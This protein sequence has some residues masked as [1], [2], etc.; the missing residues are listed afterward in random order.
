MNSDSVYRRISIRIVRLSHHF[1]GALFVGS[2]S[3]ALPFLA[4]VHEKREQCLIIR[5]KS[6]AIS[7]LFSPDTA[8]RSRFRAKLTIIM[9]ISDGARGGTY[10]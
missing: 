1:S 8:S 6:L 9:N 3:P 2:G 10:G 4:Q 5:C 7:D